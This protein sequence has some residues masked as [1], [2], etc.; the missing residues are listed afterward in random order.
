MN[1]NAVLIAT[2]NAAFGLSANVNQNTTNTAVQHAIN[3]PYTLG[4]MSAYAPEATRNGT[5]LVVRCCSVR[6]IAPP[7]IPAAS[8]WLAGNVSRGSTGVLRNDCSFFI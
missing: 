4:G 2:I 8:N 7:D 3:V 6:P 1:A 5:A